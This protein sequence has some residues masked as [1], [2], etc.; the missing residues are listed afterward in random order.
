MVERGSSHPH[1]DV[2]RP[3]K[4][5]LRDVARREMLEAAM[6]GKGERSQTLAWGSPVYCWLARD[7]IG[8]RRTA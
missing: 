6:R 5:G 4:L 7:P 8:G 3:P 1:E 2:G